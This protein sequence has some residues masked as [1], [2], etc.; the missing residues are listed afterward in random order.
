[1]NMV[2][3]AQEEGLS[4]R[5]RGNRLLGR[6]GDRADGPIPASAGQPA[7]VV[8]VGKRDWA[9]P[10]ERGATRNGG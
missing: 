9:Y 8:A 2:I 7:M 1:M 4:P 6:D 10:R 3:A 5:A